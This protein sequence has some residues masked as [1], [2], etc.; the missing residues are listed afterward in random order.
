MT[1]DGF[2]LGDKKA[3]LDKRREQAQMERFEIPTPIMN[4]D[5]IRLTDK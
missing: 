5:V 1:K 4:N 3:V 2:I